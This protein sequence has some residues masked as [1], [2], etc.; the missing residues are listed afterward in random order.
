MR[1]RGVPLQYYLTA[2]GYE[3]DFLARPSG[4]EARLV[5]VCAQPN[6][7]PA[8]ERELRALQEAMAETGTKTGTVVSM[9]HEETVQTE[10]GTIEI[11]PAWRWLL[12]DPL[13][14]DPRL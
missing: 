4:S 11:V 7:E 1:G 10:A 5:Q 14:A 6:E 12:T 3:V 8:R 2:S 13:A 9:L